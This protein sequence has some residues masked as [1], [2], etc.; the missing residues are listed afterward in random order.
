MNEYSSA[1]E[2]A[3]K[4]GV[5]HRRVLVFCAEGRVDGATKVGSFWIIPSNA[6]K[7]DDPRRL[8][9]RKIGD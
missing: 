8:R 4:W 9:A 6:E 7:P 2:I 1:S 5:S 3:K